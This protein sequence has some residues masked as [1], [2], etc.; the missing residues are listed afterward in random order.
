M[1]KLYAICSFAIVWAISPSC[2][3]NP[4]ADIDQQVPAAMKI[5]KAWE[6]E[7]SERAKRYFH[8]VYWTPKD[9]EPAKDYEARLKR[10]LEH[11][12]N[13]YADQ[14]ERL[15]FGRRTM[16][17]QV[18][19][20]GQLMIHLVRGQEPYAN[21][22]VQSGQKIRQ[23]CL[24]TLTKAGIDPGKE[25]LVIFCNM[26]DWDEQK[27]QLRHRSPYYAGGNSRAGTAWQLDSPILDTIHLRDKGNK[28]HDGQ[29]GHISLGKHNSIFIGGIAHELGHSLGLPH[30]KARPDEREV[31]GTALMGSG[32]RTYGDELRDEGKGS[33]LTLAHGLRLASHPQFSGSVKAIQQR[34]KVKLL[35][36]AIKITGKTFT[37]S[38]KAE[39]EIP[40]YAV[41]AYMDPEGGSDY[42][43][44]TATAVPDANG[45]FTLRCDALAANRKADLRLVFC[46]ANGAASHNLGP[47]S[48]HTYAYSVK[49]D[50]TPDLGPL[51]QELALGPLI[52]AVNARDR[53]GIKNGL[54]FARRQSDDVHTEA[55]AQRLIRTVT[56]RTKAKKAIDVPQNIKTIALGDLAE[57]EASVGWLR[58]IRGRVPHPDA[59]FISGGKIFKS[60]IYAHAPAR[61]VYQINNTW[62]MLRGSCGLF[63]RN[64]GS[65]RFRIKIDGKERFDSGVLKL[66]KRASYE[67]SLRGG[68]QLELLV[69]PTPDGNGNDWG[70]WLEPTLYR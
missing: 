31:F 18:N 35:D 48:P 58:P 53:E 39:S 62:S 37:F 56:S 6:D 63:D 11:I 43:A 59:L 70:L 52:R 47:F 33:F 45:R 9:R 16:Q 69:D 7:Q 67:V 12:Q 24:P 25:T 65:V 28:I 14:M 41:I 29:Y 22:N 15:G 61:H 32:N 55:I 66:G 20:S 17:L 36:Q 19:D 8:I 54:E 30:C 4:Q 68:K 44:T 38:G 26:A 5:L 23:E 34:P 60:G 13:Y 46:F 51:A 64:A 57:D 42:N 49:R 27:R 3:A 10:M 21:Y 1:K 2:L 40:I 50:G